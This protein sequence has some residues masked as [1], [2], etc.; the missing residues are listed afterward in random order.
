[1]AAQL[2]DSSEKQSAESRLAECRERIDAVDRRLV[3]LLNERTEIVETIGQLKKEAQL[4][5]YEPRR[6]EL[7]YANIVANNSGP[8]S[9]DALRRIFER[10]IDEMRKVQRERMAGNMQE[11]A[12]PKVTGGDK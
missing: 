8:L 3:T 7:V 12:A 2:N 10:V 6:E 4:P 5:V 11:M 9:S 1:M